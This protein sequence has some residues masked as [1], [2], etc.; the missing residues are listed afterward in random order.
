MTKE[1][2]SEIKKLIFFTAAVWAACFATLT[3]A[4]IITAYNIPDTMPLSATDLPVLPLP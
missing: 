1:D 2:K 3:V 4:E